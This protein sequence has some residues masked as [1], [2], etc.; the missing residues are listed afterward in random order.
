MMSADT[1]AELDYCAEDLLEYLPIAKC[2]QL[3]IHV[4]V[5][6][7]D[8]IDDEISGNKW[9]K[10]KPNIEKALREQKFPVMSF[11]GAFSNHIHA[12]ASAGKRFGFET[13][14]VIRGEPQYAQNPTL[15]DAT[16]NGMK[17]HF[18]DRNTYRQKS[19]THFINHLFERFGNATVIPEGGANTLGV[20][21]CEDIADMIVL[22]AHRQ[23]H[24]VMA[25]ATGTTFAGL[26]KGLYHQLGQNGQKSFQLHGIAVLK[27]GLSIAEDVQHWLGLLGCDEQNQR[28]HWSIHNDFHFG[29][30]SK[31]T[32]PLV[33]LIDRVGS[34]FELPLDPIYTAKMWNGFEQLLHQGKIQPGDK[35]TL[36]HTGGLQG[37]RGFQA[38][39]DKFR[40]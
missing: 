16:N 11:G 13:I 2:E 39:L 32:L 3:D 10:L 15:R 8:K 24:I 29:G 19:S 33:S 27:A 12:L 28:G 9:F 34:E 1:L 6:R 38:K 22:D 36:I 18:V 25:V 30:Y 23:H 37:I 40:Y 26:L 14:G 4:E 5:L 35:V 21:G 17:L 7:L 31:V 20:T